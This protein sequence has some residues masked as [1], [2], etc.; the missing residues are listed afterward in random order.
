MASEEVLYPF[1]LA[2]DKTN[3]DFSNWAL[4]EENK[5]VGQLFE[6][7]RNEARN[8]DLTITNLSRWRTMS[9][10]EKNALTFKFHRFKQLFLPFL[11]EIQNRNMDEE[12]FQILL[13]R[14]L[15]NAISADNGLGLYYHGTFGGINVKFENGKT[16][17]FLDEEWIQ[18][19]H[20]GYA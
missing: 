20:I 1:L 9:D 18:V 13:L 15:R 11:S 3:A 6:A 17:M 12:E 8:N 2:M 5:T 19:Y 10:N 16:F 4:T 7:L 14:Y